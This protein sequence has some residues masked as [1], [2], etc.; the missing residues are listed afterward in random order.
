MK[1]VS[2]PVVYTL[3]VMFVSTL[4]NSWS[5]LSVLMSTREFSCL[6]F[7]GSSKGRGSY[8]WEEAL[9]HLIAI[10]K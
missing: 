10:S 9:I 5:V 7:G 8:E 4:E 1:S 3:S 6:L 2:T